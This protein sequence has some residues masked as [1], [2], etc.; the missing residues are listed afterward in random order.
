MMPPRAPPDG[1]FPFEDYGKHYIV[2]P[3]FALG[4][5]W[6]DQYLGPNGDTW[7]NWWVVEISNDHQLHW[8]RPRSSIG[9]S[10]DAIEIANGI[11]HRLLKIRLFL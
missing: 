7:V 6:I 10:E 5:F 9:L 11:M 3:K 4:Q 8:I 1:C 2:T